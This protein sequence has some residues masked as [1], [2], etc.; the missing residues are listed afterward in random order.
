MGEFHWIRRLLRGLQ[1]NL[2]DG[3][4]Q[5]QQIIILIKHYREVEVL[6]KT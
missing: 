4:E 2:Q 3:L 6:A 1:N 5:G